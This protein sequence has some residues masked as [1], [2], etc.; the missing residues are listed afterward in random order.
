MLIS[1][2]DNEITEDDTYVADI[3]EL[4]L[5]PENFPNCA[6]GVYYEPTNHSW[7][8]DPEGPDEIPIPIP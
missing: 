8:P 7:I 2:F 4:C 5:I 1:T 3:D 6:D